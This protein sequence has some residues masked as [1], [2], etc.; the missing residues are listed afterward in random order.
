[1]PV[2]DLKLKDIS[3]VLQAD[4]FDNELEAA[5]ELLEK[6]HVR[7]PGV[8]AGVTLERHLAHVSDKHNLKLSKKKP[9]ISDYNDALKNSGIY[10]V[11]DWRLIQRLGDIRNLCVHSKGRE[12]TK[13]EVRELID[14]VSKV[15]KTIF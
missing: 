7:A 4:L 3:G 6:G 9:S 8:L 14:G 13:D 12:P 15:I 1:M 11:P 5:K 2:L 10:D